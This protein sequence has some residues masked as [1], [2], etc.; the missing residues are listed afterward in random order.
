MDFS[1]A[2]LILI[3]IG[4][5]DILIFNIDFIQE[6]TTNRGQTMIRIKRT[7]SVFICIILL[8]M[9]GCGANRA[10]NA[11]DNRE[12]PTAESAKVTEDAPV[13]EV[14]DKTETVPD[15]ASEAEVAEIASQ[16]DKDNLTDGEVEPERADVV[17]QV[18][19][20]IEQEGVLQAFGVSENAV[21]C[22][23]TV[24]KYKFSYYRFDMDGKSIVLL[25]QPYMGMT[26]CSS[27]CTRAILAFRPKLVCM[28]G[29]CAG[30]AGKINLGDVVV[31]SSVFDYTEGKQ[32]ADRFAP[33]PKTRPLDYLLSEYVS[34]EIVDKESVIERIR[35]GYEGAPEGT[36]VSFHSMASGAVVADDSSIMEM[37]AGIQDDTVALDMEGY[38]LAAAADNMDTKWLVIKTVQDFADGNKSAT[39]G[40]IRPYAAY[41]SAKLL[42]I[43]LENIDLDQY[44]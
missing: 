33:R 12:V 44:F 36:S 23:D 3:I 7:I 39:E 30:R 1:C 20:P 32:Y 13:T 11:S 16:E 28:T 22:S 29:I 34:S 37:I 41:S 14:A 25:M 2:R 8:L 35:S 27:L 17:I 31:A 21:H 4:R 6:M 42:Q 9:T 10:D 26:Y 5:C 38:A 40:S 19:V 24:S 18:A 15:K 43:I